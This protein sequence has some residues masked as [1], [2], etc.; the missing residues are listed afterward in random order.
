MPSLSD[1]DILRLDVSVYQPISVRGVESVGYWD[2]NTDG[3]LC[4]K[5]PIADEL[6]KICA[7]NEPHGQVEQ[8][9]S[10]ARIVYGNYVGMLERGQ[11]LTLASEALPECIITSKVVGKHL[12]R[13]GPSKRDLFSAVDNCRATEADQLIYT[14]SAK[15]IT[16]T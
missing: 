9:V 1:E 13:H 10:L 5:R 4:I 12:E 6:S 16:R 2:K 3:P 15:N 14:V 7:L 8:P 11:M